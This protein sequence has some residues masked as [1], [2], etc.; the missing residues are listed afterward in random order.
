MQIVND[1]RPSQP[2][3]EPAGIQ[4]HRVAIPRV[5]QGYINVSG[6]FPHQQRTLARAPRTFN[7]Y[8]SASLCGT[9]KR[10]R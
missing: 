1:R 3:E 10:K 2:R 6:E 4:A 5:V 7:N 9:V 8:A